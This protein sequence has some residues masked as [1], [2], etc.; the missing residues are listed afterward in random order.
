MEEVAFGGREIGI[1]QPYL[2]MKISSRSCQ[3]VKSQLSIRYI[4]LLYCLGSSSCA[5]LST[6][7]DKQHMCKQK[8]LARLTSR[9][10]SHWRS[11]FTIRASVQQTAE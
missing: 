6:T 8:P 7:R 3:K 5:H 9:F 11:Y 2:D 1:I 10:M 4:F